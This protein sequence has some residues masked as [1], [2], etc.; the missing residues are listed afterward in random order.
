M[1]SSAS[2]PR[3]LLALAGATIVSLGSVGLVAAADPSTEPND[4]RRPTYRP[5]TSVAPQGLIVRF[6]PEVGRAERLR[7]GNASGLRSVGRIAKLDAEVFEVETGGLAAARQAL[8][9]R[10]AVLSVSTDD[11]LFPLDDPSGED[12]FGYQWGLHNNR[13][14]IVTTG[15][16]N[17]DVDGPQ[18]MAVTT[19]DPS[20]V[21][22][23]IDDGVDFSH[24]DLAGRA[25]VNPGESGLDP[26]DKDR[27][28]NG[29][30]DDGNGIV[31][32][33]HGANF[34]TPKPSGEVFQAPDTHGTH[35]A[36]TIAASLDGLGVVGVA[37]SVKIMALKFICDDLG[38]T[39]GA[40]R[41]IRY[42]A[43]HGVRISN[44][45]WGGG[46]YN[47]ALRDAIR[48][49][50]MLFVA[51]AGNGGGDS[52]GDDNDSRP[53]YPSSYDASNIL[54]VAA[55]DNRGR[56]GAF[57][58]FGRTSVDIS[59]PG[60]NVLS[61]VTNTGCT[62]PCYQFWSGTSMA[63][64][65]AT[66]VAALA[67]SVRPA[68]LDDPAALKARVMASGKPLAGTSGKTV[69]GRI[70]DALWAVDTS[71]PVALAPTSHGFVSSS[72]LGSGVKVRVAWPAATDD[73][74]G[75]GTYAVRHS[76]NGG[77]W[78]ALTTTTT[79][80]TL[81]RALAIN[82]TYRFGVRARDRGGNDSAWVDG[83]SIQPRLYQ[84]STS[85][86][87]Y[88][89][90]WTSTSSSSASGGRTRYATR[91]GAWVE[92]RFNGRAVAVVS[93]KSPSR[94][95]VKIYVDG[96][97]VKTVSTYRSSGLSKVLVFARSWGSTGS[98]TVRLVVAG[99]SGHPR[100]DVDALLVLR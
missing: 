96:A 8:E 82:A 85:L 74:S 62:V 17:V 16:A 81:D 79:A 78:S 61:T 65:H 22:A 21:V 38:F 24:P 89:G 48:S 54:S 49:S 20:L 77:G 50:G 83:P 37:P 35:V 15:S 33:V 9:G 57:S 92:F 98:H 25:W 75:M 59:A 94:G 45:S 97:F 80:R 84:E 7:I 99:T 41:A 86:A 76:V 58:N 63:A 18:A 60:V 47:I 29:V 90:T 72:R 23:V 68:L 70:V 100:F 28:T 66:G 73:L 51:A 31:D 87:R 6:A 14:Q 11:P 67:A 53:T 13:Q 32:D 42:A 43:A 44:N 39:S 19:G 55:V 64:P 10:S 27:A 88:G 52:V 34:C 46:S 93:P 4:G 40:I 91:A 95:S 1:R 12:Y 2:F 30:D 56:L 5:D 3:R 26:N 69:T 71:A 36:G